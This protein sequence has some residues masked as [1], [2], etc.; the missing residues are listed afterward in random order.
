MNKEIKKGK[1]YNPDKAYI[2]KQFLYNICFL[3]KFNFILIF[4]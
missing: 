1:K 2:T 4:C 3:I